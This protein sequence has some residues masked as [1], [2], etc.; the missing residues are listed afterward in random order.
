MGLSGQHHLDIY[1]KEN[2]ATAKLISDSLYVDDFW[3]APKARKKALRFTSR[4]W[5]SL[6][7]EG[8]SSESGQLIARNCKIK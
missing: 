1:K 8:L 7:L 2:P 5:Q 4:L 6:N 3:V